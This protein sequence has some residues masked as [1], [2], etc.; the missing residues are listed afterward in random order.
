MWS[1]GHEPTHSVTLLFN[2][3]ILQI[4]LDFSEELGH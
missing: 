3:Y 4:I 1:M 2:E